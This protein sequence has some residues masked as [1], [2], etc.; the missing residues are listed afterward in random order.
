MGLDFLGHQPAGVEADARTEDTR[1]LLSRRDNKSVDK[2]WG[3][4]DKPVIGI[5]VA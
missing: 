5:R 3:A 4:V 1:R 2:L